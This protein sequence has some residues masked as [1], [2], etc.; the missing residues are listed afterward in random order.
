MGNGFED[1]KVWQRSKDLAV[2]LY[3]L[4]KNFP[5]EDLYGIT[6]QIRRSSLSIPSNLAEGSSRGS[7]KEYSRFIKI[8]HGSSSE[9]KTQIIVAREIEILDELNF[10]RIIKE[11]DEIGRML[12]GLERSIDK[13]PT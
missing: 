3:N 5:K 10:K 13:L 12:K 8:A 1:L 6:N 4:S 2:D 9:L 11:I 7:K